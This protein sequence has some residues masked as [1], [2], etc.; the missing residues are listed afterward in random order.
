M[1]ESTSLLSRPV[2]RLGM[3]LVFLALFGLALQQSTWAFN[4]VIDANGTYWGIQDFASPRVDTGS[5][6]A[7]Q[8]APGGR[9]AVYSTSI[10]GFGGI[11]V[12]VQTTPAPRFNGELMR[13]FGLE[14]DG[15]DRFK[16]TRSVNLGGVTISRSVYVNRGA[17]W[18]RWLD[19]FTNTTN[20]PLTI[21]VAFGGQSGLGV[22][23]LTTG[24][25]NSSKLVTTSSGDAVVTTSDSWAEM[26]T[27]LVGTAPYGGTQVTVIGTPSPFGGAMTF[28]GNWLFD[29]FNNPMSYAGHEGN[30]QGYVNTITLAP[31]KSRSLLHFIVLGPLVTA[32]TSAGA[33]AVVE[34]TANSLA[35]A[36]QISDLA[37]AELCSID[38]FNMASMT[39]SGFSVASC[40]DKKND[41]VAQ[42]AV[43]NARKPFTSTKYD[44]VEKT[45]GQLQADMKSGVTTSQEITRAYLDRIEYYDQGQFGFNAYEIV[46]TDAM[47]QAKAADDARKAGK[48]GALL[49][50]PIAIKNLFDTKDMA[51]T[52]GSFT[53]AGFRPTRDAFQVARLRDAG[54][55]IIGKAA[56]EEYATS[57]HYSNDAWG[58]VW[59]VF[60]PSKSALASSGGSASAVAGSLAAAAL[61][62][63]T[64]DSLYAPASAQSLVTLR[65]TDG[66]E[67]GTGVM[68]L[69]YLTDFGGAITRSVSDLADILNVVVGTDP[70]DPATA[71]ATARAPAN[72]RSVLDSRALAGKRIGY[73]PSVW[74]DPFETTGTVAAE[75]AA[76]RFLVDAG[77]TIVNMGVTVGGTDTPPAPIAPTTDIR[78]AG[79]R[80]YIDSH[81]ELVTQGFKIFTEVDVN[82][83]QKKVAYVRAA[84]STCSVAPATRMTEAEIQVWRDYRLGRQATAK[85]WMDTA[86]ADGLG[87][88]AVVYPGLLSDVSLNDG[89]GNKAA[90]G[91]RDTPGAANGIPTVVFPVGYNDHGQP[92]NIQLLGRAWDD[93]KLV[94]MA[95]AFELFAEAAGR[96]HVTPS[97]VPA[98]T[99][100]PAFSYAGETRGPE[101]ISGS[102]TSVAST[103]LSGDGSHRQQ[104]GVAIAAGLTSIVLASN[105][106]VIIRDKI[107]HQI[108]TKAVADLFATVRSDD[109][110]PTATRVA[111]DQETQRFFLLA[112]GKRASCADGQCHSLLA[113]SRTASPRSLDGTD[114]Y[115]LALR[116][117]KFGDFINLG[118]NR[119]SV[120]LAATMNDD[121]GT[122]LVGRVLVLDKARLAEGQVS[123]RAE[124][125][126]FKD[127]VSGTADLGQRPTLTFNGP[128]TSFFVSRSAG[129]PCGI[130]VWGVE[131]LSG[132][133]TLTVRVARPTR[134]DA[135]SD[136]GQTVP[137]ASQPNS[138][139]QLAAASFTPTPAIYRGDSLWVAMPA[140][141]NQTAG[142]SAV[143][144]L[145]IDVRDWPHSAT[146]VQDGTVGTD[147]ISYVQPS[148]MVDRDKNV[149]LVFYRSGSNDVA[150]AYYTHRLATDAPD[151]MRPPVPLLASTASMTA[152]GLVHGSTPTGY[153]GLALDPM[154]DTFWIAAEYAMDSNTPEIWVGAFKPR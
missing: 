54:A 65:G 120:V 20:A 154:D 22:S 153:P 28:A 64:G 38:N 105:T 143:R 108:A 93:G 148:I 114:W 137:Q 110:M 79:W 124:Y 89:G 5:I 27:P 41:L 56:L 26:A 99:T 55:V 112:S 9:D 49:G 100:V 111:F 29:T 98:L 127:P 134:R 140:E 103:T 80:L 40:A 82:C 4:Y 23:P 142:I 86:G 131:T 57:G 101:S 50:I 10:S 94:G 3:F 39:V 75:R 135:R 37:T 147:S 104:H 35:T 146:I 33:R 25:N 126:G 30:F 139:A 12:L 125:S 152:G 14:F 61:G 117:P 17:N 59:N 138:A 53:F 132:E 78:S 21:K 129:V 60:N 31:G 45:I 68:P 63:Q 113:V 18:G 115:L 121:R 109:E 32:E 87:V 150:T 16:T 52:N 69:T 11:K 102:A 73:I 92:I 119:D 145:E 67:S 1:A 24:A 13:G 15:I 47:A 96:G 88:D 151:T 133:A 136:C 77:A 83:S 97:T 84:A 48:T 6:R 95:Y 42:A 51:T 85:T 72:W 66:L 70:D 7:T 44:V 106:R 2:A 90:F 116:T 91:R 36:P 62:S 123:I 74:L 19:S 144:W 8:V 122:P 34:A 107:G 118:F 130:N 71:P 141:V 46:A 43:P 76:L 149:G 81:P 58:Q 128:T